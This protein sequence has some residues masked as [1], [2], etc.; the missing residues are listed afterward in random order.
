MHFSNSNALLTTISLIHTK[1]KVNWVFGGYRQQPKQYL[2]CLLFQM[3][4][5]GTLS[6]HN[7]LK[8][9]LKAILRL[10]LFKVFRSSNLQIN[11]NSWIIFYLFS[12]NI[13]LSFTFYLQNIKTN[14]N[15]DKRK[16]VL[17]VMRYCSKVSP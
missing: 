4:N 7:N 3:L 8:R 9:N 12:M 2:K 11:H 13:N 6:I 15:D 17:D 5:W 10:N 1:L 16:C 14:F